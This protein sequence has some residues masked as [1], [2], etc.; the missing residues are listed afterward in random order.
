MRGC[1]GVYNRCSTQAS[2]AISVVI[3]TSRRV[4]VARCSVRQATAVGAT[5]RLIVLTRIIIHMKVMN[6]II[7]NSIG[8]EQHPKLQYGLHKKLYTFCKV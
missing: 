5:Y 8:I 6:N 7:F 1:E 4:V 3:M 2:K